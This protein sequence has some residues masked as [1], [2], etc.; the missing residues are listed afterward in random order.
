MRIQQTDNALNFQANH[1]RTVKF[2]TGTFNSKENIIDIYSINKTDK[3]LINKLFLKL[4]H[5]ERKDPRAITEKPSI[6]STIRY[7]LTKA[8][9]KEEKSKYGVYIAVENN[10]KINGILDFTNSEIPLLKN[11]TVWG[12]NKEKSRMLLF[13]EFMT[14]MA[15][16][17]KMKPKEECMDIFVYSES[18]V[19][20]NKWLRDLG[21]QPAD[22]N[23]YPRERLFITD[24]HIQ[25][26]AH[27]GK[28]LAKP[29][30]VELNNLEI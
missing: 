1:L 25:A 15:K 5:G 13:K 30:K 29:E 26:Y 12:G 2:M 14:E 17:N 28:V 10:K 9:M 3:D 24:D 6:N 19:S 7:L 20:G 21:F 22:N 16:N 8:L 23:K 4:D 27:N 18:S 11:L